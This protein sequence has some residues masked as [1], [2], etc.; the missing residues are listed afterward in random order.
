V[1]KL[2]VEGHEWNVLH[3][4]AQFLRD[5]RVRDVVFEEHKKYPTAASDLLETCGY[6]I[7][8]IQKTFMGPRLLPPDVPTPPSSWE[9][10]SFLATYAP[11]RARRR[12]SARGWCALQERSSL[13]SARAEAI[14]Q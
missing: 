7:Y 8:R 1:L 4:A 5:H 11:Q 13:M 10:T 12:L 2:D 14:R 6:H 9:P 3:G